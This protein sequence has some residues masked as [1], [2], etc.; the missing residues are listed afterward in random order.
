M[1]AVQ[2]TEYVVEKDLLSNQTAEALMRF[3]DNECGADNG[4]FACD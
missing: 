4:V 3:P 1:N 2:V